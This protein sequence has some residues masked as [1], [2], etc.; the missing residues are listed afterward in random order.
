MSSAVISSSLLLLYF[1]IVHNNVYT[2][3]HLMSSGLLIHTASALCNVWPVTWSYYSI[4][5]DVSSSV[6]RCWTPSSK[7]SSELCKYKPHLTIEQQI[8][9]IIHWPIDLLIKLLRSVT[10]SHNYNNFQSKD[11]HMNYAVHV[12]MTL[13]LVQGMCQNS[14]QVSLIE[15]LIQTITKCLVEI[16]LNRSVESDKSICIIRRKCN[17]LIQRWS[18]QYALA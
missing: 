18:A 4:Q 17:D 8:R 6:T 13:H 2:L 14:W 15:L 11:Q 16:M 7:T 1:I 12:R 3:E 9:G 10:S 5:T